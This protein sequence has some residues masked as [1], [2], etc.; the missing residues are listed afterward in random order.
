MGT[1]M[2]ILTAVQNAVFPREIKLMSWS[3]GG[4]NG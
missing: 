3:F 2:T 1:Q 4:G